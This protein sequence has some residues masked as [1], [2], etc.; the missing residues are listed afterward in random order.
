MSQNPT[1]RN[2]MA[3]RCSALGMVAFVLAFPHTTQAQGQ[4]Y[5]N[6]PIRMIAAQSA[7]SSL[8]TILR[9]VTLK[10]TDL[11]GQQIVIDNRGGAGGTIGVE[12]AA[13]AAPDGYT[14]LAGATS[15][16]VLSSY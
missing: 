12:I 9:I 10:M 2:P 13:R 14:L 7:G 15:S 1:R 11:L 3:F 16:M 6:R 8:D 5:P 4:P